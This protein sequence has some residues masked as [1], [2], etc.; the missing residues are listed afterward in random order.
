MNPSPE[1]ARILLRKAEG[2]SRAAEQLATSSSPALWIVGFHAQQAVEKALKAVLASKGIAFARTHNL[3]MLAA[4]LA[5]HGLD[6][7]GTADEYAVLTPFG[8][9]RRGHVQI[10]IQVLS[11]SSASASS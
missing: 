2:D 1:E 10:F 3:T 8:V 9:I 6:A 7:P 11:E 5:R 4:L